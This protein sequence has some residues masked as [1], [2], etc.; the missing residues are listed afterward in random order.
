MWFFKYTSMPHLSKNE[1]AICLKHNRKPR[2]KKNNF[3]VLKI[4]AP[5]P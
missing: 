2:Q 4:D 5:C 1:H 3:V